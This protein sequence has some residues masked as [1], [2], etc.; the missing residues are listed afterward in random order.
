MKKTIKF[1]SYESAGE[2]F[3][4]A[5]Q[6]N[7]LKDPKNAVKR[8]PDDK[9]HKLVD[10]IEVLI[11][12]SYVNVIVNQE[13]LRK[14]YWEL[15]LESSDDGVYLPYGDDNFEGDILGNENDLDF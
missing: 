13:D 12:G 8:M 4:I 9:T 3:K 15:Y 7:Y 2:E 1:I 14:M 5:A 11:N 10:V 6:H